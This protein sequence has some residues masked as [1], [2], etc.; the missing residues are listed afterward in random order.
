MCID[1]LS[2]FSRFYNTNSCIHSLNPLCKI[3]AS[4]IFIFMTI[5]C[6]NIVV[7]FALLIVLIFIIILSNIPL[8]Y[9]LKLIF[10]MKILFIMLLIV[11]LLFGVGVYGSL[12]MIGKVILIVMYSSCL[13]MTSTTNDIAYGIGSLLRPLGLLGLPVAKV[14]MA[15]ALSLNFIPILFDTSNKILKSGKSR[16]FDYSSGNFKDKIMGIRTIF[17]PLFV[18]SIRKSDSVSDMMELRNFSFDTNRSSLKRFYFSFDDLCMIACHIIV[19]ILV[20]VKE[21][22][23]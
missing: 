20:L 11:N 6:S 15:I 7:L 2:S 4:L 23:V 1:L 17:I 12:V 9:Y 3:L 10:S 16:G 21:V 8:N 22:V 14:S 19:L 18:L 13:I 5:L